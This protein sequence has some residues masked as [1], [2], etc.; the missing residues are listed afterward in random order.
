MNGLSMKR[1]AAIGA[2]CALTFTTSS[3]HAH[4]TYGYV[5]IPTGTPVSNGNARPARCA[6]QADPELQGVFGFIVTDVTPGMWF[7]LNA[8]TSLTDVDIDFFRKLTPCDQDPDK[9][10]QEH[11]NKSGNEQGL[12]P[13]DATLAIVTMRQGPPTAEFEYLEEQ[14]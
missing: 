11:N 1:L 4:P 2:L 5:E 10:S 13:E 8:K 6:Y 9:T 12:I 14:R 7:R 3:A